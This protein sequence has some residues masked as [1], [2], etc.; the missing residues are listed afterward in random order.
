MK[1]SFIKGSYCIES[2]TLLP[3]SFIVISLE[4][5]YYYGTLVIFAMYKVIG[6]VSSVHLS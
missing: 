4:R 2:S 5:F 1:L 6:S 3:Y